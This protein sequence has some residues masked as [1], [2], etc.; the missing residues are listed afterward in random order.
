MVQQAQ[1]A[2]QPLHGDGGGGSLPPWVL[3]AAP[4]RRLEAAIAAAHRRSLSHIWHHAGPRQLLRLDCCSIGSGLGGQ[5]AAPYPPP[6]R[7]RG[8]QPAVFA[9]AAAGRYRWLGNS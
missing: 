3:R 6:S 8:V 4:R 1:R 9:V 2:I 5:R 7:R